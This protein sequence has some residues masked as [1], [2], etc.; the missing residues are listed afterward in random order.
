M[1]FT[2]DDAASG[3]EQDPV[4]FHEAVPGGARISKSLAVSSTAF[5]I[6]AVKPCEATKK[7][8]HAGKL[9]SF[10]GFERTSC[11]S[12]EAREMFEL[13]HGGPRRFRF[14]APGEQVEIVKSE[15]QPHLNGL[16]GYVDFSHLMTR[17][18]HKYLKVR[19]QNLR[20]LRHPSD[21]RPRGGVLKEFFEAAGF[22]ERPPGVL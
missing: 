1:V 8:E 9:G 3:H 14:Q 2:G 4:E 18:S 11:V 19:P 6:E 22:R 21:E 7:Q 15:S 20:P 12:A 16:Q 10:E 5:N 13:K 17:A